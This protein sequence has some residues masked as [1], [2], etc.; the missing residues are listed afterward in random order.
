MALLPG[1]G[2]SLEATWSFTWNFSLVL[3]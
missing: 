2:F 1:S 3:S